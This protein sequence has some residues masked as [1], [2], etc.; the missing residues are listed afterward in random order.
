[1]SRRSLFVDPPDLPL[2]PTARGLARLW[3]E[4]GKLVLLGL[5]CAFVYSG[6][7]LAIPTI[8]IIDWIPWVMPQPMK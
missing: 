1:V 3:R 6:L 8:I 2:W 4:Q 7:T 5:A